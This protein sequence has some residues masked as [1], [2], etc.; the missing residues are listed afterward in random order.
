MFPSLFPSGVYPK[1]T[2]VSRTCPR[3]G[4]SFLM[5]TT[6]VCNLYHAVAL[7]RTCMTATW[8]VPNER[9]RQTP[10]YS[11]NSSNG[12][13]VEEPCGCYSRTLE[14]THSSPADEPCQPRYL[15]AVMKASAPKLWN[16]YLT[17]R[18]SGQHPPRVGP[19]PLNILSWPAAKH[20][21]GSIAQYGQYSL[22]ISFKRPRCRSV[23]ACLEFLVMFLIARSSS[24]DRIISSSNASRSFVYTFRSL[25]R[26]TFF[27]LS[28]T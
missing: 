21:R 3:G 22:T 19:T 4:P 5:T 24:S 26:P 8:I 23:F 18:P 10:C 6:I 13:H 15:L 14:L 16:S 25:G 2:H 17:T 9:Q 20:I 11:K 12:P 28:C 1:P 7:K 27:I